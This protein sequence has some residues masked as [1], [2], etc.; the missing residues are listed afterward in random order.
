[1]IRHRYLQLRFLN[2]VILVLLLSSCNQPM[3]DLDL[4]PQV[5][6]LFTALQT[7]DIDTA[8]SLYSDEFYKGFPKEFWRTKLQKFNEHMGKMESYR[9]RNKQ[10]DTR[11]SGK[12]FVYQVDTIHQGD[13]KARHIITF[14]LPIDDS[15]IKLV[16]HKITAK[17]FD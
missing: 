17:G 16:G 8:L 2:A 6:K 9:I 4:T 5:D 7:D 12:F 13:K 15:G 10:A 3:P 11:Y 1:M 14:V